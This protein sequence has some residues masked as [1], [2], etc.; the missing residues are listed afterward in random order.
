[1]TEVSRVDVSMN[2]NGIE[3]QDREFFSAIRECREPDASVAGVPSCY[4]LQ[5][6][7]EQQLQGA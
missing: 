2:V 5:H 1:M 7:F 6:G 4:R 3:L